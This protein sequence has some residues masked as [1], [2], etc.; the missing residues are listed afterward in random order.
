MYLLQTVLIG[1][2][3]DVTTFCPK[4]ED[5]VFPSN[6]DKDGIPPLL[7]IGIPYPNPSS[8]PLVLQHPSPP[9][10]PSIHIHLQPTPLSQAIITPLSQ[11]IITP[12]SLA[13]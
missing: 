3:S 2:V 1:R 10:T 8:I 7:N 13:I 6:V 4:V 11:A 12:L 5:I 9:T